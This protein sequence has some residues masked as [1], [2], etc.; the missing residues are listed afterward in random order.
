[1][2]ARIL[3]LTAALLFF[4]N[5]HAEEIKRVV[6]TTG[7]FSYIPAKGWTVQEFPG[8]KFKVVQ[9]PPSNGFASNLNFVDEKSPSTLEEY[10]DRNIA[11]L[12]QLLPGFQLLDRIETKTSAGVPM[13]KIRS[14]SHLMER[15]L[16]Q[17]FYL[18]ETSPGNKLIITGSSLREFASR[19]E[20]AFDAMVSS[21]E[22]EQPQQE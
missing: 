18:L 1:M 16:F 7:G 14:H 10:A 11:S 6:E 8:M 17:V 9:F 2:K 12:T 22:I 15:D 13:V 20:P 21:V 4:H 19:D 5:V 3:L